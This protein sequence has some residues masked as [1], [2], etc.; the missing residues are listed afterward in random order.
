MKEGEVLPYNCIPI[1]CPYC[2]KTNYYM[3][4]DTDPEEREE[5]DCEKCNKVFFVDYKKL[6][7][8]VFD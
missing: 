7:P 3:Y 6:Y 2:N 8:E 1:V 5:Y 4:G